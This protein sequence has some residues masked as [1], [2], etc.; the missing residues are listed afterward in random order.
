MFSQQYI[1]VLPRN[2]GLTKKQRGF[3]KLEVKV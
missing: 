2:K 1:K 3:L